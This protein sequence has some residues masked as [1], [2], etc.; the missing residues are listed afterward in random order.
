MSDRVGVTESSMA[1]N[2]VRI[3]ALGGVLLRAEEEH[4][5]E[6]VCEAGEVGRVREVAVADV[7]GR[8][9]LG[10]V[11]VGNEDGAQTVGQR[12]ETVGA[13]VLAGLGHG[14]AG[15]RR[16]LGR[17]GL[18]LG[19]GHGLRLALRVHL[20][21]HARRHLRRVLL[22]VL[23]LHDVLHV[24]R[25]QLA[26]L[27]EGDQLG[28]RRRVAGQ[29]LRRRRRLQ[30]GAQALADLARGFHALDAGH[31]VVDR[32]GRLCLGLGVGL[33]LRLGAQ[34]VQEGRRGAAHRVLLLRHL[35]H[36]ALGGKLGELGVERGLSDD[37]LHGGADSLVGAA[38]HGRGVRCRRQGRCRHHC[39]RLL[40][41]RAH[42]RQLHGA[43]HA[44][45]KHQQ[46]RRRHHQQR[47]H[48]ERAG[49]THSGRT[50]SAALIDPTENPVINVTLSPNWNTVGRKE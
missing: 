10:G 50:R 44:G 9:G 8:G 13:L 28:Q 49:P 22:L 32:G 16:H 48:H 7:D 38:G 41:G 29:L 43:V 40:V 17:A 46:R 20:C 23:H 31:E 21:G 12:H 25:A 19:V 27:G 14:V 18:G 5:L 1:L 15:G 3:R 47:R 42:R 6:E 35:E 37:G 39:A 36:G 26:L 2:E 33:R 11:R 4:V 45:R 24:L 34:F 30:V